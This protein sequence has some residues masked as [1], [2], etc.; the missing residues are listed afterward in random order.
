MRTTLTIDSDVAERIRQETR[1]G[2]RSLKEVI[3]DRLR[4]GFGMTPRSTPAAFKV[5]PH[6]SSYQPGVDAGKLNQLLDDLDAEAC[7]ARVDTR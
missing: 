1:S 2:K 5:D 7:L 6:A 3:N 4:A